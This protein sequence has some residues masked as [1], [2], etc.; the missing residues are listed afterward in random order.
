M[1]LTNKNGLTPGQVTLQKEILDRFGSLEAQNTELKAQNDVLTDHIAELKETLEK[2]QKESTANQAHNFEELQAGIS[3][4]DDTSFYFVRNIREKL[5][6]QQGFTKP[7][8]I[9]LLAFMVLN[10]YLTYTTV[11]SSRQARDGVYMINELLRGDTS[12]WHDAD[13]H[14]LYVRNRNDTEQ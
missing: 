1:A 11:Q 8:L 12:F 2:F 14:Q 5:E 13:N 9:F 4:I 3:R 10:L 6:K 7:L